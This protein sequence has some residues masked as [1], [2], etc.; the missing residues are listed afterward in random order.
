M[1][2]IKLE[3]TGKKS[4]GYL[5]IFLSLVYIFASL[6]KID[7][8]VWIAFGA[9]IFLSFFLLSQAGVSSYLKR[10]GWRSISANDF[11]IGLTVFI[12]GVVFLNSI[13]LFGVVRNRIPEAVLTFTTSIGVTSGLIAGILALIFVFTSKPKA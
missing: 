1:L 3:D 4:I 7:W 12:S 8:V 11:V 6:G 2:K 9:G 13:F 10:K 5:A